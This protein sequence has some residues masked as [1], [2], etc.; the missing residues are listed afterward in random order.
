MIKE[1][2]Q[3]IVQQAFDK[4][5]VEKNTDFPTAVLPDGMKIHNLEPFMKR[6]NTFRGLYKT[7]SI[8]DFLH[9]CDQHKTGACY[10]NP[11]EM[12]AAVIFDIGNEK[13]PGHCENRA[14]L[15]MKATAAY[16]ALDK[17]HSQ[18]ISQQDLAEFIEDWSDVISLAASNQIAM[19][20]ME[21]VAAVRRV[22]VTT[23]QVG[24]H[25][26][27][28]FSQKKSGIEE[29]DAR[30][31]EEDLPGFLY[32][33]CVPYEGLNSYTFNFRISLVIENQGREGVK[34]EPK[35]ILRPIKM[36][37]TV[38]QMGDEMFNIIDAGLPDLD[39]FLGEFNPDV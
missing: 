32:F 9:A 14:R 37:E 19:L 5:E 13:A 16:L 7:R 35:F 22:T 31:G 25:Q 28:S 29:L 39:C 11:D 18:R 10:I 15:V 30:S 8:R 21:A 23:K 26:V 3:W 17:I 12:T 38:E 20:S 34:A 6:R 2:L 33:S 36:E 27:E 4:T 1:A 24:E